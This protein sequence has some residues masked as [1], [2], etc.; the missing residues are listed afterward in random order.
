MWLVRKPRRATCAAGFFAVCDAAVVEPSWR[1]R[2]DG[3]ES[4][5]RSCSTQ[6]ESAFKTP[7]REQ[8]EQQGH[9]YC[10][11]AWLWDDGSVAPAQ[12]WRDAGTGAVG[13]IERAGVTDPIGWIGCERARSLCFARAAAASRLQSESLQRPV[14]LAFHGAARLPFARPEPGCCPCPAQLAQIGV[15]RH[16]PPCTGNRRRVRPGPCGMGDP[17]DS[18]PI[19][20]PTAGFCGAAAVNSC[21][22][23][24]FGFMTTFSVD[25]ARGPHYLVVVGSSGHQAAGSKGKPVRRASA[26][27]GAAPQR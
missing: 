24:V 13:S 5:G 12:A 22:A 7:L 6:N 9:P 20:R 23:W 18:R 19:R 17:A 4:N 11:S 21:P 16:G 27:A 2:C 10:A 25:D 14:P 1:M 15:D 8:F 26:Q 3:I